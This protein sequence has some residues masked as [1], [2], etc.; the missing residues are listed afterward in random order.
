MSVFNRSAVMAIILIIATITVNYVWSK[1]LKI[2]ANTTT[3]T[4]MITSKTCSVGM[5]IKFD[6][7]MYIDCDRGH[8][9]RNFC[10]LSKVWNNDI[11]KCDHLNNV[12]ECLAI[13]EDIKNSPI[14]KENANHLTDGEITKTDKQLSA[15]P[16][17]SNFK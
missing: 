16:K 10:P 12:A 14:S 11:K 7:K 9:R 2:S 6:C 17:T 1:P 3:T 8:W 13:Y 5:Y 4:P 15:K